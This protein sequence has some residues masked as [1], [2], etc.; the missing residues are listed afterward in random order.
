[1]VQNIEFQNNNNIFQKKLNEEKTRIKEESRLIVKAD[2]SNNMYLF[3]SEEYIQKTQQV[4]SKNYKKVTGAS[5]IEHLD[6]S[7]AG[8]VS[9]F[10]I[11]ERVQKTKKG[12]SAYSS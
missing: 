11:E 12:G 2:K 6:K 1:M 3:S 10:E 4:I 8:L 9:K 5:K 7:A